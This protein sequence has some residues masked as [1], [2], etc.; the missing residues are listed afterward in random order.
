MQLNITGKTNHN[1]CMVNTAIF[2][3][4]GGGTITLD[5]KETQ[6]SIHDGIIDMDW[7]DLYLWAV[8]Q[9][10]IF[11][12]DYYTEFD[13]EELC[14]LLKGAWLYLELEDDADEDY[15]I[16]DISWTL[17]GENCSVSGT[18][19]KGSFRPLHLTYEEVEK[20]Y[21]TTPLFVIFSHDNSTAMIQDNG[22]T[23]EDCKR[24]IERGDVIYID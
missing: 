10:N 21:D 17:S 12:S 19:G 24:F 14:S 9:C 16:T 13:P 3:L 5:R 6:Y 1:Y 11:G 8:N 22:Y 7:I 18:G 4:Q 15:K 20:L 2:H 23:L